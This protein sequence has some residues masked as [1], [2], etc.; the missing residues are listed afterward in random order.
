M[1]PIVFTASEAATLRKATRFLRRMAQN[2]PG[3]ADPKHREGVLHA[4]L[5]LEEQAVT[6]AATD[7][8][9]RD[10]ARRPIFNQL[11][12]PFAGGPVTHDEAKTMLD[13]YRDE[14]SAPAEVALLRVKGALLELHPK[15]ANPTHGCCAVP[16]LC[17]DHAPECRSD[18]HGIGERRQWPC[19]TL[20]AAGITSDAD[21]DAVRAALVGGCP[22]NVIDGDVGGHFFK[23]GALSDSPIACI[24]CGTPKPDANSA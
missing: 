18:E 11:V 20:R 24:Y 3:A 4:G 1:Y 14:S 16:K 6:A 19:G 9:G 13:A 12:A 7:S 15:T 17:A 5:A 21:A 22:R 2:L 8:V 10:N 23:K